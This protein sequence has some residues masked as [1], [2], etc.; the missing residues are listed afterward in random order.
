[1]A[2]KERAQETFHIYSRAFVYVEPLSAQVNITQPSEIGLY[3]KA[4]SSCEAWP[5][6]GPRRALIVM[7]IDTL[8]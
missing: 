1:M 3:L 4:S 7:A 5:C 8:T 6:T 2:T